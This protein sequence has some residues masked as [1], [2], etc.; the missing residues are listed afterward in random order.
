[1]E[2]LQKVESHG[3]KFGLKVVRK[4]FKNNSFILKTQVIVLVRFFT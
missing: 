1:M 4:F 2:N 3:K